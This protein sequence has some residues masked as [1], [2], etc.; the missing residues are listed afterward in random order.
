MELKDITK[1][2]AVIGMEATL[3]DAVRAMVNEQANSLIVVDEEGK[4]TGEI[5]VSDLFEAIVPT[6]LDGDAVQEYFKSEDKFVE[7]VKEAADKPVEEFLTRNA[8]PVTVTDS[9]M[10][11]AAVAIAYQHSRIPVVDHSN[12]PIGVIS[13]QGL[14]HIIANYLGIKDKAK[15][16]K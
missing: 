6:F 15:R 1:V 3:E 13:R 5:N 10:D 12:R 11:V 14:K 2:A 4:F 8:E 7:A 9:I 16:K